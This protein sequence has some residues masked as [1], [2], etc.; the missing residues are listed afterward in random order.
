MHCINSSWLTTK[1]QTS[2][3]SLVIV[4]SVGVWSRDAEETISSI[5]SAFTPTIYDFPNK[6]DL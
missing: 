2:T 1:N 3:F 4:I 6:N 5:A